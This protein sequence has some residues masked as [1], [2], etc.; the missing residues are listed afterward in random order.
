MSA[1]VSYYYYYLL[2]YC[3]EEIRYSAI[4][5]H[6]IY[7]HSICYAVHNALNEFVQLFAFYN[8]DR[9]LELRI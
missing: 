6:K 9:V 4:Q 5:K 1:R 2:S 8:V 3:E 7:K